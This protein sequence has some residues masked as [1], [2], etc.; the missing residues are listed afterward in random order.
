[1]LFRIIDECER[2]SPYHL[3]DIYRAQM[4][5]I[6]DAYMLVSHGI[7]CCIMAAS[8]FQAKYDESTHPGHDIMKDDIQCFNA[9]WYHRFAYM[10]G[11]MPPY[12]TTPY[13]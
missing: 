1:M 10:G 5:Y 12:C 6:Y 7:G 8:R 9:G 13:A 3:R 4:L 2:L 11:R